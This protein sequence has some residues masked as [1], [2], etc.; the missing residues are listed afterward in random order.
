MADVLADFVH[1]IYTI[2]C[3]ECD[4]TEERND[5]VSNLDATEQF[6]AD[7][8]KVIDGEAVCPS[9]AKTLPPD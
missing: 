7:G 6:E 1:T 8:W 4:L 5:A 2:E 9:C 3:T